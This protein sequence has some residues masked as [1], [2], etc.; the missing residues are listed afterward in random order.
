MLTEKVFHNKNKLNS[1]YRCS[2]SFEPG[3]TQVY[4]SLFTTFHMYSIKRGARGKSKRRSAKR[5]ADTREAR[6]GRAR[7]QVVQQN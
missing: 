3:F 7:A 1:K 4:L 6:H 2:L 5:L